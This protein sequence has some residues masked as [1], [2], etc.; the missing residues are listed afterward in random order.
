MF[1]R[2]VG[3]DIST[4]KTSGWKYQIIYLRFSFFQH[5]NVLHSSMIVL[6]LEIPDLTW[7]LRILSEYKAKTP[8]NVS[9]TI[10]SIVFHSPSGAI[11]HGARSQN[12]TYF[13]LQFLIGPSITMLYPVL[14]YI[15]GCPPIAKIWATKVKTT[16]CQTVTNLGADYME[17]FQPRGWT[18][19]CLP[20]WNFSPVCINTKL[21]QNQTRDYMTKFST[22][23]WVQPRGWNFNPA[24]AEFNPGLKFQ[25]CFS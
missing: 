15:S 8:K 10:E 13:R 23:G 1:W 22:Q 14:V 2:S 11:Q 9:F 16:N 12:M 17:N 19:P 4:V 6:V 24:S 18:Q 7:F 20:G 21:Y 3:C 25:P 5:S